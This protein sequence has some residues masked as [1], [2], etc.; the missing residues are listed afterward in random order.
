VPGWFKNPPEGL[1]TIYDEN[2]QPRLAYN[3][4][5]ADLA[6]AGPPPVLSRLTQYPHR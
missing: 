6:F 1:A 5:R 4:L 2:Y 3:L